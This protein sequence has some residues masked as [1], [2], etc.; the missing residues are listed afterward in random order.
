MKLTVT[1]NQLTD[2]RLAYHNYGEYPSEPGADF[3]REYSE[4]LSIFTK[5]TNDYAINQETSG[6][7]ILDFTPQQW[8]KIRQAMKQKIAVW[9]GSRRGWS[10]KTSSGKHNRTSPTSILSPSLSTS[11]KQQT[12]EE[13]REPRATAEDPDTV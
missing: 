7:Y 8:R 5:A 11:P 13:Q 6:L 2:Y 3:S 10:P 12:N 9:K 4:I 1:L